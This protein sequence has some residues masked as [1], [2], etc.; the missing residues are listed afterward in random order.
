MQL[1]EASEIRMQ[2]DPIRLVKLQRSA[3]IL[4]LARLANTDSGPRIVILSLTIRDD[5]IQT[6]VT[7]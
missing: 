6:I 4:R 1:L 5:R 7:T 3:T 2:T